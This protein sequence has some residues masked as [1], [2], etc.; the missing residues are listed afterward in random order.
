MRFSL[1]WK[2]AAWCAALLLVTQIG[3]LLLFG[4]IGR[5]SEIGRAHV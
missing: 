1:K 3:G 5:G 4:E 2:I